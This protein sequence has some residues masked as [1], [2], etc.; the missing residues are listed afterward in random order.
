[1]SPAYGYRNLDNQEE[2]I[3]SSLS[4]DQEEIKGGEYISFPR[5]SSFFIHE[6]I[7]ALL[8]QKTSTAARRVICHRRLFDDPGM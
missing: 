3:L 1:V 6:A 7:L 5:I 8:V 4:L 2:I